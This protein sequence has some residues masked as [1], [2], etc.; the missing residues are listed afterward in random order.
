M[1]VSGL[2][3]LRGPDWRGG[4]TD[5]GEGHVGTVTELL[6][7]HTMRVLWDMGQESTCSAGHD[8]N[9]A[10]RIFD[11]AQI[12]VRHPDTRC[13]SCGESDIWGMLW[14]CRDCTGCDLCPLCYSDDKHALRHQFLRID[15]PGTDGHP[16]PKRKTSVKHRSL[17]LFPGSKVSRG[18]DWQ[19][20]DQDGGQGS[21]GQVKGYENASPHSCR[22]LQKVE[23]PSGEVNFYRVGFHGNVDVT[24]VEEEEGPWYYRDHL[25][26]LDTDQ[27]TK[28]CKTIP[29]SSVNPEL[30]ETP[31]GNSGYDH[32]PLLS[33]IAPLSISSH[34]PTESKDRAVSE[35][36]TSTGDLQ[37]SKMLTECSASSRGSES[38][39]PTVSESDTSTVNLQGSKM[40]TECSA[41]SRGSESKAP[42]ASE[43]DTSTVNPQGSK[44][45]TECRASSRGSESKAPTDSDSDTSTVNPQGC[46]MLTEC[47]ASSR[48]SDGG[49]AARAEEIEE[50][51]I[52]EGNKAREEITSADGDAL[53]PG[54]RVA[55]RVGVEKLLQLQ[56]QCRADTE[57]LNRVLGKTGHVTGCTDNGSVTVKFLMD[58]VIINAK[59]LVTVRECHPGDRVR[60]RDNVDDVKVLNCRVGWKDGMDKTAGKVGQ[61]LTVDSEGD[62]LVSFGRHHF[63]FAP[64]CCTHVTSDTPV[65]SLKLDVARMKEPGT[66]RSGVRININ[67]NVGESK[68]LF[69]DLRDTVRSD[70]SGRPS[71]VLTLTSC[72][73]PG[74]LLNAVQ[75]GDHH[76]VREICTANRG[77]V[78]YEMQ[79][80]TP[81]I[82]ASNRGRRQVVRVLLEL[83]A[84]VNHSLSHRRSPMAAA[85]A[86]E[87]EDVALMLLEKGADPFGLDEKRH[88]FVHLAAWQNF[89]R[90]VKALADRGVDVN[91]Q[92]DYS[93]TAMHLAINECCYQAIETLLSIPRLDLSVR[94]VN[95]FPALHHA[96]FKGTTRAAELILDKDMSR[97][98]VIARGYS[99]LHA[100]A[101][102]DHDDCVRLMVFKGGANVNLRSSGGAYT[103]LLL[104]CDRV[105]YR[106][107]EALLELGADMHARDDDGGT[108]L[109]LAISGSR[110]EGHFGGQSDQEIQLRV[111]LACLLVSNGALVDAEDFERRGPLAKGHPA[112]REG[113]ESFIAANPEL[114]RRQ[115]RGK[116]SLSG[117]S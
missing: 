62:L 33:E 7:D 74:R 38:K 50:V 116:H 110:A 98:N 70:S 22:S 65:D 86:G 34:N 53:T 42:T 97:A 75:R 59:A 101:H 90:V 52:S 12:G 47:R 48:G 41:S 100:A 5:G 58:D 2:R 115:G 107:A 68:A 82:L 91:A 69:K 17:G 106:A 40:L 56:Q 103:P 45:I 57:D 78:E 84:D 28:L 104:A 94:N 44:M 27:I 95:N 80:V 81:L 51:S 76:T 114:V 79:D 102:N 63:L 77:L 36:D 3:V 23:W 99:P 6:G 39:A 87:D 10:L 13:N 31:E 109:H 46:K 113:V 18:R 85:L 117:G 93:D 105:T 1:S 26:V 32:T 55:V 112:I 30:S 43:S 111:A 72:L 89:P 37:G 4:D 73:H 14:R 61:V 92:D 49:P 11:T 15:A 67:D 8:G 35:S 21:E 29:N 71:R 54:A 25:P 16:V 96:C 9:C 20:G 24:C 66:N 83:G 88:T 108:A 60:L 64:A 19:W